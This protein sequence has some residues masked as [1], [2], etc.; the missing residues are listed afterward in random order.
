MFGFMF[1][2]VLFGVFIDKIC[3]LWEE[4]CSGRGSCLEYNNE[5]FSYLLVVVGL[6]F[7]SEFVFFF[8]WVIYVFDMFNKV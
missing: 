8:V 7:Q 1:G 4:M 5:F 2:F 3:I 6:F